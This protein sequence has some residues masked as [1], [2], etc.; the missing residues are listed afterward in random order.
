MT[1]KLTLAFLLFTCIGL[2]QK[3][4]INT[5]KGFAVKG[6][7]VVSY[8]NGEPIKGKATYT[9]TFENVNYKFS[10]KENLNRFK[11]SPSKYTPQYGGWCAYAIA[12]DGSKVNIN[13]KAYKI[14]DGKLYL[15]YKTF[16]INTLNK[17]NRKGSDKMLIKAEENWK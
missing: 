12:K 17:W 11:E 6:Y 15:F 2:S 16:F 14:I 8:F 4:T 10:S 3:A 7:D 1:T 9:T 5:K 13:P